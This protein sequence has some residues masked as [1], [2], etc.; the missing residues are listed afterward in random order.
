MEHTIRKDRKNG[1]ISVDEYL[2]KRESMQEKE[3][4]DKEKS[5]EKP[6]SYSSL[7]SFMLSLF[8]VSSLCVTL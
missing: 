4:K 1:A 2:K 3:D 5:E 8:A 6:E 7:S